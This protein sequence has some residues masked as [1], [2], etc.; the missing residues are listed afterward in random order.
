MIIRLLI[1][2]G[3][4]RSQGACELLFIFFQFKIEL[5]DDHINNFSQMQKTK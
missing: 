1:A 3:E 4:G 2:G 5:A